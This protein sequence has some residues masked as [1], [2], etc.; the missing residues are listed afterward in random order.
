MKIIY[1]CYGG[2]HSSVVSA[3]IHLGLLSSTRVATAKELNAL[4]LFDEQ[5]H[6]EHGEFKMMG[7]DELGNEIYVA[8]KCK[9]RK[10]FEPMIY[11]L[12]RIYSIPKE[13]ILLVN[14]M[15]YVNLTMMI[16][17]FT[18]R[19]MGLVWL[20]RPVVTWGTQQAYWD[21]V[22]LVSSVKST[23]VPRRTIRPILGGSGA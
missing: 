8:G 22:N 16:G 21:I 10:M 5:T 23:H 12:A 1:H 20:G 17:G 14:T 6:E 3:A 15:P 4:P 7:K 11:G 18:S 2:S 19:A 9:L 13:D